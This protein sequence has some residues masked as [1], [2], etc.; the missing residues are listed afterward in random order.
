MNEKEKQERE[1]ERREEMQRREGYI[2]EEE[3]ITRAEAERTIAAKKD[4]R[5]R[6]LSR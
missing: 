4:W 2:R 5:S 1:E 6:P 3:K